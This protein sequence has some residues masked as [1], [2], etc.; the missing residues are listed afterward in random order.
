MTN[1]FFNTLLLIIVLLFAFF[2]VILVMLSGIRYFLSKDMVPLERI[3]RY[4]SWISRYQ[5]NPETTSFL[6]IISATFLICIFTVQIAVIPFPFTLLIFWSSWLF[7]LFSFWKKIRVPQKMKI[8]VIRIT[9]ILL[10][11]ALY[12]AGY[13]AINKLHFL[14]IQI[15]DLPLIEQSGL[16]IYFALYSLLVAIISLF[17]WQ[18]IYAKMLSR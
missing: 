15:A 9:G 7:Q 8:E 17:L 16:R 11:T 14:V 3:R 13:F 5:L 1:E 4:Q 12:F 2:I 6:V 10:I 18:R